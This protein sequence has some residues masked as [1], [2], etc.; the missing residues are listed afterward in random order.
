MRTLSRLLSLV[1]VLGRPQ[2]SPQSGSPI[3]LP[4]TR[5][6]PGRRAQNST[7]IHAV[8]PSNQYRT[9]VPSRNTPPIATIVQRAHLPALSSSSSSA[10]P[11]PLSSPWT[12]LPPVF[13][14]VCPSLFSIPP[15]L[16]D[17]LR[18]C[19][20]GIVDFTQDVSALNMTPVSSS[21]LFLTPHVL[22]RR[23]NGSTAPSLSTIC[24]VRHLQTRFMTPAAH[25]DWSRIRTCGVDRDI[26]PPPR[27][28]RR[29]L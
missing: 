6:R 8:C 4:S 18:P 5:G 12:L 3:S 20:V 15:P 11:S 16:A 28:P 10:V 29:V 7:C 14:S 2:S 22:R 19:L 24:S 13:P 17:H 21:L 9:P 1:F 26:L 23:Q 25:P 27:P